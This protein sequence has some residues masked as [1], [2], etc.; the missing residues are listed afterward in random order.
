MYISRFSSRF[1]MVLTSALVIG[2]LFFV[3]GAQAA[4]PASCGSAGVNTPGF[5]GAYYNLSSSDPGMYPTYTGPKPNT[6]VGEQNP[7][8]QTRYL[9][10]EKVETNIN[11]GA[12]F[13]P[14]SEGKTGDP[15]HFAVHWRAKLV[16]TE[17]KNYA[18]T[19]TSD[20]DSWILI[21]GQVVVNNS[22]IHGDV[23]KTGSFFIAAGTH[24]I[25]VFF[26]ERMPRNSRFNFT[27]DSAIT[28]YA[29]PL[30]CPNVLSLTIP[31]PTTI[32][33]SPTPTPTPTPTPGRVLGASTA[34]Y[35]PAVAL[36][37]A[38]GTPD[39][40][41]IY[42]N[43]RRHLI[44]GPTAFTKYG[45]KYSDI[46]VVPLSVLDKHPDTVLVRT[47]EESTIYYLS[48]RGN[49][50]WLKIPLLT[51]TV[52]ASYE[53]NFWGDVAVI[54]ELDLTTYQNVKLVK[55]KDS[56]AIYL[57]KDGERHKFLAPEILIGLGYNP[58]EALIITP[59]HLN[60]FSLGEDLG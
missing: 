20:D 29:L 50:Q 30:T 49:R 59:T 26:A 42:G 33:P 13:L 14:L 60:S 5:W 48:A 55:L 6:T 52:F 18:F 53:K 2:G 19:T 8:Y 31:T 21:D 4:T 46:K 43:G 47:P 28:Y 35:T 24:T 58:N 10:L 54:D 51:P 36:Y 15:H 44:S 11:K 41:A 12:N 3:S 22:G 34:T 25:D 32:S 56:S 37:R 27:T 7:W 45:Y 16:A 40:Y 39:I 1:Q 57:I 38:A 9:S 23:K 17:S